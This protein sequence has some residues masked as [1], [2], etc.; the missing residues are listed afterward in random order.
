[1]NI[2]SNIDAVSTSMKHL[3]DEINRKL[4][5]MVQEFA[6][7]ATTEAI[8]NTPLGN[9]QLYEKQ[10]LARQRRIGLRPEEG[11]ARGSWRVSVDGTLDIQEL[12]GKGSGDTAVGIAK[13]DIQEYKLGDTIMIS[14]FGY[15]IKNLEVNYERYN[16]N[17]PILQ[18]TIETIMSQYQLNLGDYYDRS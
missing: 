17:T 8:D 18:P 16:K 10:Y 4:V 9:A 5:G 13:Q 6:I 7:A 3:E 14:N 2:S 1:M 15:Y 11:F 12:Y